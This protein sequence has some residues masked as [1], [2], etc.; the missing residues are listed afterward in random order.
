MKAATAMNITLLNVPPFPEGL[1]YLDRRTLGHTGGAVTNFKNRSN[2]REAFEPKWSRNRYGLTS[3]MENSIHSVRN[4]LECLLIA[5]CNCVP[6]GI[7]VLTL[8]YYYE[9]LSIFFF[10]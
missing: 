6:C 3:V 2:L 1:P 9:L 10:F 5:F 4:S 7:L 8:L